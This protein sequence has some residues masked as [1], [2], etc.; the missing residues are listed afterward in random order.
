MDNHNPFPDS[1]EKAYLRRLH[2]KYLADYSQVLG[3]GLAYFG[4]VS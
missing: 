4:P 3:R 1:E 2:F